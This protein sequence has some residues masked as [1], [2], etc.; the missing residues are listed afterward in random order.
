M[1]NG[2]FKNEMIKIDY[3]AEIKW[4]NRQPVNAISLEVRWQKCK[5][6]DKSVQA[7]Q[8]CCTFHQLFY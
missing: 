7:T 6:T 5:A 3:D 1:D 2:G 4:R 8:S